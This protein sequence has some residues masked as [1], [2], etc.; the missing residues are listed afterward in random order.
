ML[1]L[2]SQSLLQGTSKSG[3]SDDKSGKGSG[4]VRQTW[5][6]VLSLFYCNALNGITKMTI[7]FLLDM[8]CLF[9]QSLLQGTYKS[10]S[11]DDKS[12]SS[13]DSGGKGSRKVRQTFKHQVVFCLCFIVQVNALN[14][15]KLQR[16]PGCSN[17]TN[18]ICSHN[19]CCRRRTKNTI[20]L[21]A[22]GSACATSPRKMFGSLASVG[23]L[24]RCLFEPKNALWPN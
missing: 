20:K 5:S 3:S 15:M 12:S 2:F 21:V 13:D 6:C 22:G 16:W 8:L 4:K 1:C 7:L 9:S 14:G 18:F 24:W 17:M 19:H 23:S 10:G 11:S